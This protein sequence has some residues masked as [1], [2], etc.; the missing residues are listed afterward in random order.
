LRTKGDDYRTSLVT[1]NLVA[2]AIA[3]TSIAKERLVADLIG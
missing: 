3:A 1:E 2:D